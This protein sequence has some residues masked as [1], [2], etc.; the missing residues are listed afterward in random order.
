[1]AKRKVS[2]YFLGL[3]MVLLVLGL[4]N[5]GVN[6]VS[7]SRNALGSVGTKEI[8]VQQ[9]ANAMRQQ[10]GAFSDQV[11]SPVTMQQAQALG[12]DRS[13]LSEIVTAR[14]L[15]NEAALMG[16]SVGDARVL[17][18]ILA[19][20]AFQRDGAFDRNAYR[21]TLEQ[22]NLTEAAFETGLRDDSARALLQNA[23]VGGLMA[24]PAYAATISR[25][26]GEQRSV[27]WASVNAAFLPEPVPAPT[28]AELQTFYTDNPDLFTAPEIRRISYVWLTPEMIQDNVTVDD[29][30]VRDLYQERIAEFVQPERRVVE[31]LVFGTEEQASE[32]KSRI[33]AGTVDFDALVAE[34]GLD[35]SDVDLGDVSKQDLGAAGDA[36]FSAQLGDVSGPF[37]TNLGPALFRTNAVLAATEIPFDVA[38]PDLRTELAN[39]RARR[40]ITDSSEQLV[41]L[42]AGGA[43]LADLAEQTDLELGQ[44]DWSEGVTEGIAAYQPF[45]RAAAAVTPNAFP[46]ILELEDGGIFALH[47]DEIVPPALRPLDDVRDQAVAAWTAA[48]TSAAIAARAQEMATAIAAGASFESEGLIPLVEQ[49]MTRQNFIEGTPP[50][51]IGRVFELTQGEATTIENGET[52]IVVRIDSVAPPDETD[53]TLT[54]QREEFSQQ[55]ARAI[56][57]DVFA[58][59]AAALQANTQIDIDEAALAAVNAQIN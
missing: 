54:A 59:F 31:R 52:A 49:N 6:G 13:V 37:P 58:V 45:R 42:I 36:V 22:N 33:D 50:T 1:M 53:P 10:L 2:D 23:V 14:T 16:L 48:A 43:T 7:G 24:S 18:Q 4:A 20:P 26:V 41:N 35:L 3:V 11:G 19:I 8:T 47:L 46:E 51:F 27:T 29:Q 5:W 57:N 40:I 55:A 15:D 12:I 9:Y 34:R 44:I 38:E 56:A 28:D 21:A 32:A 17:N 30:A 25:F 39:Q